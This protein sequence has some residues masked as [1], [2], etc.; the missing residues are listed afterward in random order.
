MHCHY[1]S[2]H[3]NTFMFDIREHSC[4]L[5]LTRTKRWRNIIFL[6]TVSVFIYPGTSGTITRISYTILHVCS[7]RLPF[8]VY[9]TYN[10]DEFWCILS[11]LL[12]FVCFVHGFGFATASKIFFILSENGFAMNSGFDIILVHLSQSI[13]GQNVMRISKKFRRICV[14][15]LKNSFIKI[16]TSSVLQY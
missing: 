5:K 6:T 1:S 10:S 14:F 16:R 8:N 3:S 2:W 12:N 4:K 15:Y 13:F 7:S 9:A 11:T